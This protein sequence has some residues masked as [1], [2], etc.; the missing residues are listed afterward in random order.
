M[1]PPFTHFRRTARYDTEIRGQKIA[2]GQKVVTW[3]VSAN[4]DE[5]EFDRPDVYDMYRVVK[6]DLNFGAGGHK[7]LGMHLAMAVGVMIIEELVKSI[8]DYELDEAACQ[9]AYGEHLQGFL[10]VPIRFRLRPRVLE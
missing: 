7:C 9:R 6:R 3:M 2:A 4:R 5:A 8:G 10:R 1:H